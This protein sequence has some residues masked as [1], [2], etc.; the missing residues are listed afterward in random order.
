MKLKKWL[1]TLLA[2]VMAVGTL[3]MIVG[4]DNGKGPDQPDKPGE[5]STNNPSNPEN[6]EGPGGDDNLTQ[7]Y[8][9]GEGLGALA[10][11]NWDQT[12]TDESLKFTRTGNTLTITADLYENDEFAVIHNQA[13]DG[14]MGMNIVANE[15][16]DAEGKA[17]F[18]TGGGYDVKNIKVAEGQ[19]GKYKLT[20]TLNSESDFGSNSLTWEL[21]EAYNV[22]F[23]E[24]YDTDD[25]TL[26]K[27][28]VVKVGSTTAALDYKA[29]S[30]TKMPRFY[31]FK[32]WVTKTDDAEAAAD[33]T[34]PVNASV[35]FYA[36]I[37]E[38]ENQAHT[39]DTSAWVIKSGD[40]TVATFAQSAVYTQHNY[41]TATCEFEEGDVFSVT[42]GTV[43]SGDMTTGHASFFKYENEA[44]TVKQAGNYEFVL[45]TE[46]SGGTVTV[47]EF[48]FEERVPIY[49]GYAVVGSL[50]GASWEYKEGINPKM[51]EKS[52]GSGIYTATLV[53]ETAPIEIKVA[54]IVKGNIDWNENRWGDTNGD[55]HNDGGNVKITEAGTYTVT[56]NTNTNTLTVTVQETEYYLVGTFIDAQGEQQNFVFV[57][58]LTPKLT[59]GADGKYTIEYTFPDV[60]ESFDWIKD[61]VFA[62]KVVSVVGGAIENWYSWAVSGDNG[63]IPAAGTYV[64]TFD[65][66][67]GTFTFAAK[68]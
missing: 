19:S 32:N 8:L 46:V 52:E 21:V 10:I 51:E 28:T 14:Q 12:N 60:H 64:V 44:F 26:I 22:V 4:C 34:K 50:P 43:K 3:G 13:W 38:V 59:K 49:N 65:P 48:F 33:F 62:F 41:L 23:A 40:E 35:A 2:V 68:N 17:V 30:K 20:V 31:E 9:V 27:K 58:G 7:Y 67:A 5:P 47:K 29:E 57:D 39:A 37:G 63:I 42:N 36:R 18:E 16:K 6:P 1:A 24:W 25:T 11:S 54:T 61:G 15:G 45:I 53:V 56:L 66:A 55:D